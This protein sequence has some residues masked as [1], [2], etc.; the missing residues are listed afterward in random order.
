M[1][2]RRSPAAPEEV[3]VPS[4]RPL[5]WLRWLLA[6]GAAVVVL[7]VGGT[8]LYIHV[9]EGPAPVPLSLGTATA[10]PPAAQASP[11]G[12]A[13]TT[14]ASLA[15]TWQVAAGSQAGYRVKEVLLG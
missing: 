1:T 10:S 4:P 11:A 2:R 7:A 14:A 12:Q 13:G 3:T 8:F 5:R 15:G 6:A 9:I